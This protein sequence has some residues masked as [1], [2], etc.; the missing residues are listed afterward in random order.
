MGFDATNVLNLFLNTQQFFELNFDEHGM[1][2]RKYVRATII[3]TL[4][5]IGLFIFCYYWFIRPVYLNNLDQSRSISLKKT[6]TISFGKYEDQKKV[7]GI[8]LE[9]TGNSSS[10]VDIVLSDENGVRHTAAVKGKDLDFVYKNE[11]YGDSCFIQITPRK[12]VGGK[13][14]VNCRFLAID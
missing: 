5:I 14:D 11:W 4:A 9:I 2:D 7:F 1:K 8:E 6:Q 12:K 10:N 3:S 13:I